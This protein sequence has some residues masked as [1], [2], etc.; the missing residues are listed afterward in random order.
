MD[1]FEISSKRGNETEGEEKKRLSVGSSTFAEMS[2]LQTFLN[3][4]FTTD[5]Q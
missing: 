1:S 3:K 4:C 2:D 5:R